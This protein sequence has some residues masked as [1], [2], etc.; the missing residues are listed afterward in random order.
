[1]CSVYAMLKSI[2]L[3]PAC[4]LLMEYLL[5]FPI[6]FRFCILIL[7]LYL[8]PIKS[9]CMSASWIPIFR[10]ESSFMWFSL[11]MK[12]NIVV[13]EYFLF[14]I[15]GTCSMIKK[16]YNTFIM[17]ALFF[18]HVTYYALLYTFN[19]IGIT[20]REKSKYDNK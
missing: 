1:M 6:D 17:I 11:M 14:A 2:F 10:F 4:V 13:Y 18:I 16:Q 19:N 12:T 7:V 9:E 15:I 8:E 3:N 5:S 20:L